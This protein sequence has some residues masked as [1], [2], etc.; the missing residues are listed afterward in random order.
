MS[1]R[2]SQYQALLHSLPR[3]NR[4]TL[5]AVINHLYCVQCFADENQMNMHN[6]AIVFGPTLFQMDG[7]DNSAGQVVE[8]LIQNYQDIFNSSFRDSWT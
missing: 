2:V 7:T 6:L 8:D 4:A 5:G 3:V 1:E